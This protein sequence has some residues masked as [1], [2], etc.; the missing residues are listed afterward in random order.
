MAGGVAGFVFQIISHFIFTRFKAKGR[1]RSS[2][3]RARGVSKV[4]RWF[5]VK[6]HRAPTVQT[7]SPCLCPRSKKFLPVHTR[8]SVR[9]LRLPMVSG[10]RR[11]RYPP[12]R[13]PL[14]FNWWGGWRCGGVGAGMGWSAAGGGG[15]RWLYCLNFSQ[16]CLT[17]AFL[18]LPD[19]KSHFIA[20]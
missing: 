10:R 2:C 8:H 13:A 4:N 18:L 11:G 20:N 1:R 5:T 9:S 12:L 19:K 6:T 7:G 17:S 16:L 15:G 3:L 14:S